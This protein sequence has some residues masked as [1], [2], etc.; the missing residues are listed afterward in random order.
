MKN[1]TSTI[2][3][4]CALGIICAL[5]LSTV[6]QYT[7]PYRLENAK[8]EKVLNFLEA[9]EVPISEGLDA[10][11]LLNLYEEKVTEKELE[12]ITFYEYAETDSGAKVIKAI[13]VIFTG[14]GLWGPIEG[15]IAFEPDLKTIRGIRFYKQ[16]ETPGLGGEIGSDWF[17][18]QFENKQ[19]ISG[20]NVPGFEII[21]PGRISD[22]N[23]VDGI[24]GATMTCDKVQIILETLFIEIW[25]ERNNY[26]Q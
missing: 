17:Q 24:S 25:K 26:V 6:S 22:I 9:L 23:S 1:N 21:K 7:K 14:A 12:S 19:I 16:E 10:K 2:I 20:N 3:F 5:L 18:E 15:V 11:G 8:L 13:A 4:A